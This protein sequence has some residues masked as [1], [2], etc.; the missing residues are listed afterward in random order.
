MNVLIIDPAVAPDTS[1]QQRITRHF[2]NAGDLGVRFATGILQATW[3]IRDFHP[4]VIVFDRIDDCEQIGKVIALLRK[5]NPG[6]AMFHLDGSELIAT[7][8]PCAPRSRSAAPSWLQ[9]IAGQWL[10]A[11]HAA[12]AGL[13]A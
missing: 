13:A 4:E 2:S 6:A 3:Q 10:A 8:N 11:R 9:D 1:Y 7:E 5:V 12:P